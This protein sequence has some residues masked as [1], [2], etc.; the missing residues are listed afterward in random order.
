MKEYSNYQMEDVF[1]M[2]SRR[3]INWDGK[4]KDYVAT[5]GELMYSE[6]DASVATLKNGYLNEHIADKRFDWLEVT[7]YSFNYKYQGVVYDDSKV[8]MN[9]LSHKYFDFIDYSKKYLAECYNNLTQKLNVQKD[10][11]SMV[12]N[13]IKNQMAEL[14]SKIDVI[15]SLDDKELDI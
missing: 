4:L 9:L 12:S 13:I 6:T 5:D 8:W 14:Q 2:L 11:S 3:G 7:P 15:N 10:K 1:S